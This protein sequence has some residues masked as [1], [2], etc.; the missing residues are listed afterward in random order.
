MAENLLTRDKAS[1]HVVKCSKISGVK[2]LK[3]IKKAQ[4]VIST[5]VMARSTCVLIGPDKERKG[6]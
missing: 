6:G 3:R 1:Q 4:R 5:R 2:I